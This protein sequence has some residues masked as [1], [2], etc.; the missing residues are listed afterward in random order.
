MSLSSQ[1][2]LV[3]TGSSMSLL[4][5]AWPCSRTT[6]LKVA[7]LPTEPGSIGPG[8]DVTEREPS[9]LDTCLDG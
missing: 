8:L 9:Q 6:W 7:S 5:F 1:A 2:F 3:V 4:A